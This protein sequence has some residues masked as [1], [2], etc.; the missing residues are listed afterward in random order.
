[1]KRSKG[2]LRGLQSR[3][4]LVAHEYYNTL[5]WVC[6]ALVMVAFALIV[7]GVI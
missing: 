2:V 3:L 5:G 4:Y 1:M 7:V 6:T